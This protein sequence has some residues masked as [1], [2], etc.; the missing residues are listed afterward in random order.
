[1]TAGTLEPR[2]LIFLISTVPADVPSLFHSSAPFGPV[3]GKKRVPPTFRSSRGNDP[4]KPGWIS[5]TCTVPA[6]VPLLFHSSMPVSPSSEV[7]NRVPLMSEKRFPLEK[8]L[9]LPA[10]VSSLRRKVPG[11]V[12]SLLH[13]P[14]RAVPRAA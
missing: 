3:G 12:P 14:A 9:A 5:L 7:K 4:L 1:R 13:S 10:R 2:A 6:A 11:A 8:E